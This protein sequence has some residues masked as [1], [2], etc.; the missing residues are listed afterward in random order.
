MHLL[1]HGKWMISLTLLLTAVISIAGCGSDKTTDPS[2]SE[3]PAPPTAP[4]GLMI[5]KA[6]E[7]GLKLSWNPSPDLDVV[8]Y[9]VYQS[10]NGSNY[11]KKLTES[12][13]SRTTYLF[14]DP[15]E[16]TTY[17]FRVTATNSHGLESA[18]TTPLIFEW[19]GDPTDSAGQD[20]TGSRPDPI[21][22]PDS[23]PTGG[24]PDDGD[25]EPRDF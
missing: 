1:R 10:I 25:R 9:D 5:M 20:R 3:D 17:S 15:L 13:V 2:S 4:S 6:T 11:Y 14:R 18:R 16:G 7:S 12:A 19:T 8:G 24:H 21:P 22:G 23:D